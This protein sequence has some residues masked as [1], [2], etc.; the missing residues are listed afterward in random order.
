MIAFASQGKDGTHVW[1]VDADGG[2]PHQITKEPGNQDVPTWSRDGRTIY[3]TDDRATGRGLWRVPASGGT[4]VQITRDAGGYLGIES[5]DGKSV[6][7]QPRDGESPVMT[8]S[9]SGGPPRQLVKC[10]G[11]TAFDV[12]AQG[13]YYV[14]CGSAVDPAVHVVDPS[15]GRDRLLGGLEKYGGEGTRWALRSRQTGERSSTTES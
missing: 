14:A 6:L 10:A 15:T 11:P 9:L 13:V 2:P 3:Y 8:V 1:T 7:Y 5:A 4:A 12:G